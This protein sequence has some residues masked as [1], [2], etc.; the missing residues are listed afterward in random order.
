MGDLSLS[1]HGWEKVARREQGRTGAAGEESLACG[2]GAVREWVVTGTQSEL[3]G[4]ALGGD[5][6][7]GAAAG[8]VIGDW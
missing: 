7:G 6:E 5:G 8:H 4:G 1:L 3:E 2:G